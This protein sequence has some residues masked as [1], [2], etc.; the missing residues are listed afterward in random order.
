MAPGITI[1][2]RIRAGQAEMM[3]F[4]LMAPLYG[5]ALPPRDP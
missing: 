5:K 1:G 2:S 3:L 4:F